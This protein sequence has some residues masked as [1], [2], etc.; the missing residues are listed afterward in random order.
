MAGAEWEALSD[1]EV[2]THPALPEVWDA[3]FVSHVAPQADPVRLL[4]E[5]E[6]AL[7]RAGCGHVK[8]V[9]DDPVVAARIGP[10]LRGL[11]LGER[12][13][14]TMATHGLVRLSLRDPRIQIRPVADVA[15]RAALAEVRDDVRREAPWYSPEVSHALDLWEDTQAAAL[16]LTWLVA[17]Y[18]DTPAGAVGLLLTADG[19]SL[20]S[21][22]TRPALRRR[23]IASHLVD[24]VVRRGLGA[25]RRWVSLLTD[26][27]DRPRHLYAR[28]GFEV[29]GEVREYLRAL[30]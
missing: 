26:R 22:A 10:D 30:R 6:A 5:S 13:Y 4:S 29:V 1:A 19:A 25:G 21:L 11:G 3:S 14:V 24:E 9:V 2:I 15:S 18:D 7:R 12:V 20:Q 28:L 23:G 8:I 17:F 27:D 16:D